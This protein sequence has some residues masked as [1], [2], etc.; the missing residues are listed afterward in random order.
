[1]TLSSLSQKSI[2]EIINILDRNF[3]SIS[4]TFLKLRRGVKIV[5]MESYVQLE[6]N[7][8]KINS[9]FNFVCYKFGFEKGLPNLNFSRIKI[10]TN[11]LDFLQTGFFCTFL[12]GPQ[13]FAFKMIL[14]VNG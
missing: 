10:L 12:I 2:F 6:A 11:T 7:K 3:F 14:T 9:I 8:Y 4:P 5:S 13:N 1:M